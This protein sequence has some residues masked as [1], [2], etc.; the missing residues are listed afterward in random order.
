MRARL[1]ATIIGR[2]RVVRFAQ[3][4]HYR[5]AFLGETSNFRRALSLYVAVGL[6]SE[7]NTGGC[8]ARRLESRKG[9]PTERRKGKHAKTAR[10]SRDLAPAV[11]LSKQYVGKR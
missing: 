8:Q 6:V 1:T 11:P 5:E 3:A 10:E 9:V 4:G 7:K 2:L